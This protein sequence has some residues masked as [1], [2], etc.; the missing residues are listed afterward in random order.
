MLDLTSIVFRVPAL[1]FAISVH[2]YAHAQCSDSL[3]DPTARRMGRLTINPFAH[4]DPVGAVL[5]VL[6]GFGWAKPVPI[7][8]GYFR[9]RRNG[10]IKVALS[11]P[12]AN[13]FLCF[14]AA[15]FMA[16]CGRLDLLSDGMYRFLFWMQLY[17]VWFAFFNLIPVPPLDGSRILTEVLQAHMAWDFSRAMERYGFIILIV[18]VFSGVTSMV[19]NPLSNAYLYLVNAAL[20]IIF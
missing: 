4:L 2:E 7:D 8:A 12:A 10:V 18:L 5:L 1:L 3:G 6:A 9:N 20:R 13:L 19:I 15:F 17:N 16:L 11:G 14:A